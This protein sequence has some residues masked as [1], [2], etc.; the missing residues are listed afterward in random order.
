[1]DC[2]LP[3]SSVHGD[4]PGKDTVVGCHFL[5]QGKSLIQNHNSKEPVLWGSAF[6][7][8]Q[9]AHPN[10]KV[11]VEVKL[12]SRVQL[13]VTPWTVAYQAPP[14][15]GFSRQDYWTGLPY[16][17]PGELLDPGIEPASL[18]SLALV[19]GFFITGTTDSGDHLWSHFTDEEAEGQETECFPQIT[20][21]VNNCQ[22]KTHTQ[23][24]CPTACTLPT[25]PST[26]QA[27]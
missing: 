2:S 4:S 19:S 24:R 8:V 14:S 26:S 22:S 1:M 21:L 6:F 9:V 12:L 17:P 11:K 13:S 20:H 18:K 25:R 15:T 10:M 7:T 27:C 16:S 3:G 23:P 5:L